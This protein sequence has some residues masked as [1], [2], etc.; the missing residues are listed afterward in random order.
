RAHS[1][2]RRLLL[3]QCRRRALHRAPSARAAAGGVVEHLPAVRGGAD[4]QPLPAAVRLREGCGGTL[5]SAAVRLQISTLGRSSRSWKYTV[6]AA[7]PPASR[8]P[9]WLG[10]SHAVE[11]SGG[12]AGEPCPLDWPLDA[13]ALESRVV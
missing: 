4:L 12:T 2:T 9:A 5:A 6:S 11:L 10:I 13:G 8:P 1:G 7:T 3:S